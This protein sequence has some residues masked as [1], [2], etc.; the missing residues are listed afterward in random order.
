MS[1]RQRRKTRSDRELEY[2][3]AAIYTIIPLSPTSVCLSKG[4]KGKSHAIERKKDSGPAGE[5]VSA[6]PRRG[7]PA[8]R[9]LHAVD[10][11]S[12]VPNSCEAA[13][14]AVACDFTGGIWL[15]EIAHAVGTPTGT[16]YLRGCTM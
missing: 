7:R 3:L 12:E 6:R 9:I 2:L 5:R 14:V 10:F 15:P 13:A 4:G 16:G 8:V 1:D 11:L